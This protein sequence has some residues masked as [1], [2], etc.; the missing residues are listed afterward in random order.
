MVNTNNLIID[1]IF[2]RM[3]NVHCPAPDNTSLPSVY[4]TVMKDSS[5]TEGKLI[6]GTRDWEFKITNPFPEVNFKKGDCVKL[7]SDGN[8]VR[9][10]SEAPVE[11]W[12]C[13]VTDG[14][15]SWVN[16]SHTTFRGAYRAGNAW[17]NE[18]HNRGFESR[19]IIGKS[20]GDFRQTHVS[21]KVC[22]RVIEP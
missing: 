12:E 18:Q 17:M 10:S 14:W 3:S 2:Q 20:S 1:E 4:L 5:P 6:L 13:Y 21:F 15:E 7:Y 8:V 19:A 16:S 11:I 22:K 9:I